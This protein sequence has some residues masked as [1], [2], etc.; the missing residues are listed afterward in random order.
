M[1]FSD[2]SLEILKEQMKDS[3]KTCKVTV[4]LYGRGPNDPLVKYSNAKI[5]GLERII[6]GA[7]LMVLGGTSEVIQEGIEQILEAVGIVLTLGPP[8]LQ[9]SF[10]A[11]RAFFIELK[12]RLQKLDELLEADRK[13]NP[14]EILLN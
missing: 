10:Y 2:E 12:S 1:N 8:Q 14:N 6:E 4:V 7:E 3:I 9:E 13:E 11:E 5:K